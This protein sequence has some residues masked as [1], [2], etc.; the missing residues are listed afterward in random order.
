MKKTS[1][2]LICAV[3]LALAATPAMAGTNDPGSIAADIILVRPA[4]LLATI[5]GSALF[6]IGLPVAATSRSVDSAAH[7]LIVQPAAATF[8]RRLGDMESLSD[9]E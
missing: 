7:A 9:W 4:C 2:S 3:G 1:R 6:V 5:V 8:T